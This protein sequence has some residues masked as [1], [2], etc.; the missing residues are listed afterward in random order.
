MTRPVAIEIASKKVHST[1]LF[2][3]YSKSSSSRFIAATMPPNEIDPSLK[4]LEEKFRRIGL[5][6][7]LTAEALKSKLIRASL[8][9]TID[10]VPEEVPSDPTV[11]GLLLSLATA[12][13]K[14]TYGNR[15]KVVKAIVDGRIKSARQV[16]GTFL[17]ACRG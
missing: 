1:L 6:D 13:Q 2:N 14:G 8:D 12:T 11:G 4:L 15:P 16:D 7:K 9:K 17:S 10:E 3:F 5:N